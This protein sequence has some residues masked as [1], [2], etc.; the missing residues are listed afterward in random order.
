MVSPLAGDA[1]FRRYDRLRLD[2]QTAVLMDA[3]PPHNDVRPFL[4]IDSVLRNYGLSAPEVLS[5]DEEA[6]LV[7]LDDL[8]DDPY[9]RTLAQGGDEGQ[10]YRL[11]VDTLIHLHPILR[12][13]GTGI[14]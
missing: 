2:G 11:A 9:G 4:A 6:V 10:L 7:L 1:S 8:C 12:S 3:P 14:G 13:E 5:A